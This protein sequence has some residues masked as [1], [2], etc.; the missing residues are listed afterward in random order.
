[1]H[2]GFIGAGKVGFS[3]GKYLT[4]RGEKV[5]G[6]CSR[7]VSSAR[8]AAAFTGSAAYDSMRALVQECDAVFVTVPDGA[9]VSVWEELRLLPISDKRII[10]CSG[11]LSSAVFSDIRQTSACGYSI[12]PLLA[13]NDKFSSYQDFDRAFFT[14]EGDE[15]YL[16]E[17]R[18]LFTRFGNTVAVISAEHKVLY[19]TAAAAASNLCVGLI[20]MSED[21]L[22]ECGFSPENAHKALS[23]LILGNMQNIVQYGTAQA[24][25]GPIE[26]NDV[27]TVRKHLAALSGDEREIY[28]LLSG[29]VL[30]AAKERHPGRDYQTMEGELNRL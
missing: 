5:T 18:G 22:C 10:H 1:M 4:E 8:E 29:Q 25:T 12:H 11:A 16:E 17:L 9:I 3:M 21:L 20:R 27:A 7:S 15:R 19:H 14:I 2:F 28:R 13:V 30:K 6:Y 23:P 26:R 24:L